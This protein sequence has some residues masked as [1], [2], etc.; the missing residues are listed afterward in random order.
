MPGPLLLP[1]GCLAL[2]STALL[3]TATWTD[4]WMVNS[5]DSVEVS[6]KCRGLWRECV[7]NVLDGIRT[8]D[9]Y[10]SILARHPRRVVLTRS[11]LLLSGLLCGS[12]MLALLPAL[13]RVRLLMD[14]WRRLGF[15][16]GLLLGAG[17]GREFTLGSF[18][19]AAEVAL[20]RA[21]LNPARGPLSGHWEW[22]WSLW[23]GI[24]GSAGCLVAALGLAC[25]LSG[26]PGQCA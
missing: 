25:S 26:P 23:F 9:Q 21:A 19:F 10:G 7:T 6:H 4:C 24:V 14:R 1:M 17:G 16:A 20:E 22:G 15:V 11:L 12:G 3:V 13:A 18:W 5:D 8:C 2:I